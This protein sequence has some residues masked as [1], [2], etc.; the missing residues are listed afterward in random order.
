[1]L[2]QE[3]RLMELHAEALHLGDAMRAAFAQP[4]R[5]HGD[6]ALRAS[7]AMARLNAATQLMEA[8]SWLL[9]RHAGG[10]APTCWH[11]GASRGHG[12]TGDRATVAARIDNLYA[13]IIAI[14]AGDPP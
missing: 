6:A 12:L 10:T 8:I 9:V 5:V 4:A 11:V 1:M 7:A 13:R 2:L 14:D 3:G